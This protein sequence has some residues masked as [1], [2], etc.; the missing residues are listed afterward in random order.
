MPTLTNRIALGLHAIIPSRPFAD[1]VLGTHL[2]SRAY[3]VDVEPE[4]TLAAPS[5]RR[6][7][8]QAT[9][10]EALTLKPQVGS[11]WIALPHPTAR[12]M[13]LLRVPSLKLLHHANGSLVPEGNSLVILYGRLADDT[14]CFSLR[15]LPIWTTPH[16]KR[17][18]AI[19]EGTTA[20][21]PAATRTRRQGE[22][23][24]D[25]PARIPTASRGGCNTCPAHED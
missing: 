24:W 14:G 21:S 16:S 5:R 25:R 9:A 4:G 15:S 19:R 7:R 6:L 10:S 12:M 22:H 2:P 11:P 13:S 1:S 23:G 8:G 17:S 18:S 20:V 3:I